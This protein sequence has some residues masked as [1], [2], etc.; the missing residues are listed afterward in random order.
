[1]PGTQQWTEERARTGGNCPAVRN[2]EDRRRGPSHLMR[3]VRWWSRAKNPERAGG[4]LTVG[5]LGGPP[6]I[7]HPITTTHHPSGSA[8]RPERSRTGGISVGG[9]VR[10]RR[11]FPGQPVGEHG[12]G[13]E[14]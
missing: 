13:V 9:V 6:G 4:V 7:F 3:W 2:L 10:C 5:Q 11:D 1:M 14:L 12:P 8:L